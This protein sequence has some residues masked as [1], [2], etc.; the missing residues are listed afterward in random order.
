MLHKPI[1]A[2]VNKIQHHWLQPI[3]QE[4]GD[5]LDG[6]VEERNGSIVT[7]GN[8]IADLGNHNNE[9]GV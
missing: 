6:Y 7:N 1:L 3:D 8:R 5:Q 9:R 2:F 4:F